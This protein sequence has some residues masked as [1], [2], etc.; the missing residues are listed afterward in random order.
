MNKISVIICVG[1]SCFARGNA[2]N[3]E[4]VEKFF[5]E[6]QIGD[7]IELE[8]SGKLCAGCC[9]LGPNVIINGELHSQMTPGRLV[10]L[11]QGLLA[12]LPA[13]GTQ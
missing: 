4:A 13:G 10:E 11:L 7:K 9:G 12:G 3:I 2:R 1:S 6:H 8:M 5:R